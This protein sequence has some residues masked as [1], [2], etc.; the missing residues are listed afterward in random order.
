MPGTV[1]E[2]VKAADAA[3]PLCWIFNQNVA[4]SGEHK[5]KRSDLLAVLGK[6]TQAQ[7]LYYHDLERH[8][9]RVGG[10]DAPVLRSPGRARW[11][12]W[13][14]TLQGIWPLLRRAIGRALRW[15]VIIAAVRRL[16]RSNSHAARQSDCSDSSPFRSARCCHT[17]FRTI[18]PKHHPRWR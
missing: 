1:A 14:R 10:L 17:W 11:Q 9:R 8:N 2:E 5:T 15:V 7:P 12:F 16:F 3:A 13:A 6:P 4:N 18:E